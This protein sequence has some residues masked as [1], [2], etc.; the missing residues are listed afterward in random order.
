V[1]AQG[2]EIVERSVTGP[3][4]LPV[5]SH[6]GFVGEKKKTAVLDMA[7][8]AGLRLV[9]KNSRD[10]TVTTTYGVG[11]LIAEALDAGCTKIIIGCGDSGTSDGG[12]GMLQALGAR[13]LDA[14]GQELPRAAGGR[15]LVRLDRID[16]DNVHPR[17]RG[18]A[19]KSNKM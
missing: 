11:Q 7:A 19:G 2:G 16:W 4:G 6:L 15:S 18:D 8:A 1:V 14:D 5:E 3:I 13:L 12:A 10:P 9:P 17:L